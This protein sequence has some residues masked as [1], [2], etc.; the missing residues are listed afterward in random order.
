MNNFYD[1]IVIGGGPAGLNF[2][3][4]YGEGCLVLEAKTVVNKNKVC[5]EAISQK[6]L[7]ELGFDTL[8][9]N[10]NF[11]YK[12]IKRFRIYGPDMKF[13]ETKD[14]ENEELI[15][16]RDCMIK[17][18]AVKA[19]EAGAKINVNERVHQVIR[20]P[21]KTLEV[22]TGK[23]SYR[24]RIVIFADGIKSMARLLGFSLPFGNHVAVCFQYEMAN[25]IY[26]DESVIEFFLCKEKAPGGYI[27]IFPKGNNLFNVGVGLERKMRINPAFALD[28]FIAENP[29][30]FRNACP[31][32]IGAAMVTMS[33]PIADP[34]D[35][36]CIVI[37]E[38]AGFVDPLTGGGIRSS[39]K[40]GRLAAMV[41]KEAIRFHDTSK[42]FLRG[43]YDEYMKEEGKSFQNSARYRDLLGNFTNEQLTE[44]LLKVSVDE[45]CAVSF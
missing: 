10:Y 40:S 35:D 42:K 6:C 33:G 38:A 5:G 13:K 32:G 45:F 9:N 27:W 24:C 25:V 22:L 12:R 39:A 34:V 20:L 19:I 17:Y 37:G 28:R 16:D 23:Q 44:F 31:V 30:R 36:G 8:L 21:D 11:I 14:L 7:E 29:V 15:V 26:D 3:R 18:V 43:F 2:A 1:V 4:N 41:T